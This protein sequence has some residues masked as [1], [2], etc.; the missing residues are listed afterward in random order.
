M[1]FA[2]YKY[3]SISLIW[4]MRNYTLI[5]FYRKKNMT[6]LNESRS[7]KLINKGPKSKPYKTKIKL[8]N[9]LLTNSPAN[10]IVVLR[11]R[12]YFIPNQISS[13]PFLFPR[14]FQRQHQ[15]ADSIVYFIHRREA[16]VTF[17]L[18]LFCKGPAF[19]R[20]LFFVA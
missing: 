13:S 4:D 10:Y 20:I 1:K 14:C 18:L 11:V 2:L 6:S 15:I 9:H 12:N 3:W 5:W 8:N 19:P 7:T 16:Q 17:F